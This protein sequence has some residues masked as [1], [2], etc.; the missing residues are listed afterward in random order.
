MSVWKRGQT[1]NIVI[2]RKMS[3]QDL[4]PIPYFIFKGFVCIDLCG[5]GCASEGAWNLLATPKKHPRQEV[6]CS[7]KEILDQM[8]R[9]NPN[10]FHMKDVNDDDVD[11]LINVLE[12]AT[13]LGGE[14]RQR[15]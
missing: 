11:F 12:D 8:N 9:G 3:E 15:V 1:Y 4:T 10:E 14:K 7:P 13:I 2:F 5:M 6:W